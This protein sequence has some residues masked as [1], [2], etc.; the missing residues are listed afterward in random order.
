MADLAAETAIS[1]GLDPTVHSASSGG[2]TVPYGALL[3]VTNTS[4]SSAATL[5]L[6]TPGTVDG[7][8]EIEDREVSVPAEG[9]RYVRAAGRVYRNEEGRVELTY[10]GAPNLAIEVID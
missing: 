7:D 1:A 2:D 6:V 8:L 5:T 3:R 10:T 4:E 9:V